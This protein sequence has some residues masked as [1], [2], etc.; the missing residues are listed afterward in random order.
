MRAVTHHRGPDDSGLYLDGNMGFGFNRL[1]IIDLSGGHQPMSN[2]DGS[3]TLVF[4]GE[5][6]NF[7]DVRRDLASRG[8]RFHTQSDTE[9]ILHAWEEFGESCV[10]H[11]RG[12]FAFAIWDSRRKLLFGARDRVGIKPF[13][14]YLNHEQFAFAS[15]IKSLLELPGIP[16]EVSTEALAGFLHHGYVIAPHTIL[17][18]VMKLPPGH[19]ICVQDSGATVRRYWDVPLGTLSPTSERDAIEQFGA[20]LEETVRLHLISDV[21]LGTFLSGGIDSSAVV[22]LMARVGVR[23][24]KTFSIGYD[25]PE[26]ELG[27]AKLVAD[28]YHTDHYELHLTPSAF[29]DFLPRIVWH[30]DE[31]VAEAP[32]IPL[33][34]LSQFARQKVTVA[35]SGEGA[36][37]ILSGYGI[38]NIMLALEKANKV[39][40]ARLAG[41][42]MTRFLPDGKARKYSQMLGLPLEHR[43]GGVSTVFPTETVAR[44]LPRSGKMTDPFGSMA[45]AY[46]RCK[47]LPALLR[48]GYL[49]LTT[50]LPDD[51]LIK[52]DRM[53]M[54][55]SLELRVPFL[56]H[57]VVEFA[58]RLPL[59]LKIRGNVNKYLLKRYMTPHLPRKIIDRAKKGFPVPKKA[60]FRT[61]L[62]GF[63]RETLLAS[64]GGA[65]AFFPRQEVEKVLCAHQRR[66]CS[67]QI[68]ALLVFD[69][70]YRAYVITPANRG[71][72]PTRY[73]M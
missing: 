28:Y 36:D 66:D 40:L 10:D 44:L 31:P 12:M 45:E 14:Y 3:V 43:Y 61:D 26:S 64:G 34:Y 60:W 22:A 16:R 39:P 33:Y 70:W 15:E 73:P 69:E 25:S 35:L 55:N 51:I 9:V 65:C 32:A 42:L 19:T 30:M 62:A 48:M 56:D 46:S 20:L 13:Y 38:Y 54:A 2:E 17:R 58:A 11:L 27:Y 6:Y 37:E 5:I 72:S 50:W 49:D 24:I 29:R 68:Y 7:Q 67:D 41:A 57:K 63:A 47:D 1:S 53:S 8:Y 52:A 59:N 71:S 23:D 18:D 4:N 21:P